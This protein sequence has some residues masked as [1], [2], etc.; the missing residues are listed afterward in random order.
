MLSEPIVRPIRDG[1]SDSIERRL[2]TDCLFVIENDE[3]FLPITEPMFRLL[4]VLSDER[5]LFIL[6]KVDEDLVELTADCFAPDWA[7]EL[8]EPIMLPILECRFVVDSLFVFETDGVLR[9]SAWGRLTA[10][11]LGLE[12]LEPPI[13]KDQFERA[14]G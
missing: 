5:L 13:R 14:A 9:K 10:E 3:S 1:I 11:S 6:D 12:L 7:D 4:R 2:V 8:R